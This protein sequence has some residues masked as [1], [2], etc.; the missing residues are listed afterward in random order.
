MT[1]W[2]W[3]WLTR[4]II[5][6]GINSVRS[7]FYN[8]A[9]NEVS[10]SFKDA[11]CYN[12][13][14]IIE[15]LFLVSNLHKKMR[16]ALDQYRA[17][18][19]EDEKLQSLD[20][21]E[22]A[23]LDFLIYIGEK[24]PHHIHKNFELATSI[25]ALQKGKDNT[26]R[27]CIKVPHKED[28][29]VLYI[30]PLFR[31][32]SAAY[33]D[34]AASQA[35]GDNTAAVNVYASGRYYIENNI[36]HKASLPAG[37][38]NPRLSPRNLQRYEAPST[39]DE[40]LAEKRGGFIDD[41]WCHCW[42]Q[43]KDSETD[44]LLEPPPESCYKSTLVVPMTLQNNKLCSMFF[45]LFADKMNEA[46][47]WDG[48]PVEDFNPDN[49][50]RHTFG[51]FCLDHT[52]VGYFNKTFDVDLGYFFSDICTVYHFITLNFLHLSKTNNETTRILK[53]EKRI[54]DLELALNSNTR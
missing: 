50:E 40:I 35:L 24:Y 15:Y 42:R 31:N 2:L 52:S 7:Y 5:S 10:R 48:S 45:E 28:D 21:L 41:A 26:P 44:T 13:G 32:I 16:V 34:Y 38:R 1:D 8:Q 25:Y 51:F 54:V 12:Q 39:T 53:R 22:N 37:Y 9:Q 27:M 17:S 36:P 19:T 20:D 14:A 3:R 11:F 4:R 6:S 46:D 49:A 43:Y 47:E 23:Y 29:G 18:R 33:D 30:D